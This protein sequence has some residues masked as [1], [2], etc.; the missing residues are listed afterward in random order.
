MIEGERQNPPP[1]NFLTRLTRRIRGDAEVGLGVPRP[2]EA[3]LEVPKVVDFSTADYEAN[4]ELHTELIRLEQLAN[5]FFRL[6]FERQ[7]KDI[8][9]FEFSFKRERED[10][11][12][13]QD[14]GKYAYLH[15]NAQKYF[16]K[17]VNPQKIFQEFISN[18]LA[19][20]K[21]ANINRAKVTMTL[22]L[23]SYKKAVIDSQETYL[24]LPEVFRIPFQRAENRAGKIKI[25]T[26]KIDEI[27]TTLE[28]VA[29]E[30]K[31]IL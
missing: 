8:E 6:V 18:L 31:L 1:L 23:K 2:T 19:A 5:E 27:V 20:E 17:F 10:K 12:G 28:A 7:Q 11:K 24:R 3:R 14:S 15:E 21:S 16:N 29:H 4:A 13:H 26:D 25:I 30:K 22:Y 9:F